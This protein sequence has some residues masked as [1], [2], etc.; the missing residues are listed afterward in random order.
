MKRTISGWDILGIPFIVLL[1]SALHF[2][3]EWSGN[4]MPL[5]L[6]AAV[7][8]SVWEHLKLAFWPML[9]WAIVEFAALRP[10]TARFWAAKGFALLA[11]PALIVGIFY[12]YTSVLGRNLLVLD[13][14]T[15]V[16]AVIAGQSLSAFL[17][18][19]GRPMGRMRLFGL[20]L[21]ACQLVAYST[22]TYFPPPGALFIEERS[23]L[24]G[25]VLEHGRTVPNGA[26]A[27]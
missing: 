5:A 22:W 18:H 12:G 21:L 23:G 10:S 4:W 7:N 8:E 9:L 1:G 6:V 15:F 25:I 19:A 14:A 3:F 11:A 26:A 20:G 24:S 2:A 13:I 16:V 27:E 17:I